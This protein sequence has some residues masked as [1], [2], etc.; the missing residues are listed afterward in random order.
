MTVWKR[1]RRGL[2]ATCLGFGGWPQMIGEML[3]PDGATSDDLAA[4]FLA[5]AETKAG[6]RQLA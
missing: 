3:G 4:L 6:S 2:D 5:W 1:R